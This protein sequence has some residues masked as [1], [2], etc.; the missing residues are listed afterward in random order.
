MGGRLEEGHSAPPSQTKNTLY[1]I[2]AAMLQSLEALTVRKGFLSGKRQRLLFPFVCEH[3][4]APAAA[5]ALRLIV[6]LWR[7]VYSCVI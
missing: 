2:F 1:I 4:G 3:Q 6:L 5:H 7:R